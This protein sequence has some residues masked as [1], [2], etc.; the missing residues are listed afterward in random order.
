MNEAATVTGGCACGAI[1]YAFQSE[2]I[3][4]LNCHCRDCQH[5]SGSGYGSF[6]IVW[7]DGFEMTGRPTYYVKQSDA[8]N[9]VER[10]FCGECGSPVTI[11]EPHRPKLIFLHAGSLDEPNQHQ[12]TMDI[13]ASRANHWDKL[14][15]AIDKFDEMPPVP[16]ELGR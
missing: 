14:D 5:A 16:D 7:Q 9:T 11:L 12:P 8:G 2:P 13:F 3:L 10:G 4:A 6:V 1:R 15:P